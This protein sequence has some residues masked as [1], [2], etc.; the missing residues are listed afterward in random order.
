[1]QGNDLSHLIRN[2]LIIYSILAFYGFL[3]LMVIAYVHVKF[4]TASKGLKLLQTEW[5]KAQ[6]NHD[7][8]VGAAQEK[9]S[10]LSNVTAFSRPT[11]AVPTLKTGNIG[12]EMR[13]QIVGMAKR[14]MKAA[15][16]ARSCGLQEGE[17]EVIL[18]MVRLER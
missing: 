5:S 10:K 15:D 16:I 9:L 12:F 3:T 14:G 4:R 18:G 6:S 11:P 17:V 1:V 8:I 2:P 7:T 13:H